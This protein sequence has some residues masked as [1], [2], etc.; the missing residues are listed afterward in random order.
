MKIS[1]EAPISIL[2]KVQTKTDYDYCLLHMLLQNESYRDWFV[3]KA[4]KEHLI[5]DNSAF[6]LGAGLTG[7]KIVEGYEMI[8]PEFVVAPDVVKDKNTTIENFK[9]FKARYDSKVGKIGGV[10][11]G[12]N[13]QEMN[14]CL[15]FMFDNAD[16]VMIPAGI[17]NTGEDRAMFIL[18]NVKRGTW[19]TNKP[20]HL[21]GC[22]E[23][24]EY[25]AYR[26]VKNIV[27]TD[28]SSPVVYGY[29]VG[30]YPEDIYDYKKRKNM[31]D[32]EKIITTD[33]LESIYSNIDRFK[34]Y[35]N[36]VEFERIVQE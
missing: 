30:K 25:S 6:E 21:L 18:K 10:V 5:L 1:H 9:E 23:L 33:T 17:F 7:D 20:V 14:E 8:H 4:R 16:L 3:N 29:E 28:T 34:H 22:K 26:S 27:S 13:E 31:V 15:Q 2:D 35:C 12:A 19:K 36:N 24:T 11:Q 32:Y